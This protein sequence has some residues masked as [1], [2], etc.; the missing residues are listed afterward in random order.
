MYAISRASWPPTPAMSVPAIRAAR[1]RMR[2]TI[3]AS[4]DDKAR[5]IPR[6]S[7]LAR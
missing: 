1:I 4:C 3:G 7:L 6:S 5:E 2:R